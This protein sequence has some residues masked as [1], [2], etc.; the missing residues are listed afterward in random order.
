MTDKAP[1]YPEDFGDNVEEHYSFGKK[2]KIMIIAMVGLLVLAMYYWVELGNDVKKIDW[3]LD[4]NTVWT[5][6]SL[7]SYQKMVE[8]VTSSSNIPFPRQLEKEINDKKVE[9]GCQ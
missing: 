5:C 6:H 3:K 9:L 1:K 4:P 7:Q 8:T 2:E